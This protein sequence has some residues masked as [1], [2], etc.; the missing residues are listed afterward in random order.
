MTSPNMLLHKPDWI[1]FDEAMSDLD[2]A[3]EAR[4]YEVLAQQVPNAAVL[5]VAGR[6]AAL[7]RLP[8]RWTLRE[9]AGGRIAL[10]AT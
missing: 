1:V 4:V 2:E 8:R 3:M 7:E 5:S 10:E 6:P 9:S